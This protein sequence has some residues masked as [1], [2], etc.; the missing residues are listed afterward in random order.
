MR[1]D[2]ATG[3]TSTSWSR[4]YRRLFEEA[5]QT[6]VERCGTRLVTAFQEFADAGNLELITCAGTHGFL[7]L[8]S[9][10]PGAVRAQV[11]T[12]VQEHER[13]FGSKPQ[14][15]VG[16]RVRLLSR[17]GRGAGRGRHPLFRASTR[18]ASSTPSRGRCSASHAPVYCP[19]G[20][21]AFGRHPMTSKLVWSTSVGYPADLQL[22]RILPR[23]RLRSRPGLPGAVPVR[24]GHPHAHRHQVPPH[25]RAR[26]ENKH[27]YN[28]DWAAR[29]GREA[30]PRFRRTAAATRRGRAGSGMPFPPVI[31]S[32]YDAELF[33]HWWFEGPQWIYHVL[34]ELA[35]GG[36]L[37]LAHAGRVP[38][39]LPDPAEGDAGA[40][41]LGQERL[42][43]ALGQP[44][45]RVDVAAAARGGGA[46]AAGGAGHSPAASPGSLEDRALRQ[47]GRELMLAQARTG[48][49]S[50][51]TA[52]PR[53]TPAAASSDHLNR[54]HDLL[55]GL[56]RQ[57]DRRRQAGSAGIHGRHLP[58]A[59]LS[60]FASE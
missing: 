13:I 33:G 41:Q 3:P 55:D 23:H 4:M 54:F 17:P 42:Q 1:A 27:L 48:R 21:A 32:P 49:S 35:G 58:R 52:P 5:R 6:F 14:G 36:D 56:E 60:L 9:S 34:R 15:H 22:P 46:D 12:A 7:P 59:G 19:S 30:R 40:E 43:R 11:F 10:E 37:A 31:V 29:D 57:R 18:T 47:A 51:P 8:L 16:A 50:S 28:P 20:V 45:D 24:Q 26:R 38:G 2:Q 39:R 53:S 25:H 44:E